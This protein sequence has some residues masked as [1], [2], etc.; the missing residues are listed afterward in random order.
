MSIKRRL[1]KLEK[2]SKVNQKER[3]TLNMIPAEGF[4]FTGDLEKCAS[5]R[6]QAEKREE[7][8]QT[9]GIIVINC[10]DCDERCE[11]AKK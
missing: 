6:K 7:S 1:K 2:L 3:I 11:H 4:P 10:K 9:I 8:D 5:Y